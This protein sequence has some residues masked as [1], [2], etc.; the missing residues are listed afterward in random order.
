MP[1]TAIVDL[2]EDVLPFLNMTATPSDG[3]TKLQGII[4]ACSDVIEDMVGHVIQKTIGPEFYNGGDTSLIL[5]QAPVLSITTMI[6]V[7][8]LIP[9]TLTEQ[10]VGYPTDNFGYSLDNPHHGRV[11]RRSAGSQPFEFYDNIG[12]VSVTYVV[13]RDT[14]P[15][16]IKNATLELIKHVYQFGQQSFGP[17][18][19]FVPGVARADEDEV[20][21]TPSGYLV[22]NRVAEMCQPSRRLPGFA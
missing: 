4:D 10:P 2:V 3:G 7:I 1:V 19:S 21:A 16:H 5:R 11:T 18:S 14:V 12:N 13:G 9:Y 20:V 6:E 17:A 15:P 8:G 22:P